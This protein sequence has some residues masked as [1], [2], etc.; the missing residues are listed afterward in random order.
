MRVL[1]VK[2]SNAGSVLRAVRLSRDVLG[3]VPAEAVDSTVHV[4]TVGGRVPEVTT[5]AAVGDVMLGRRVGRRHAGNPSA[6]LRPLSRRLASADVTVGNFEATLSTDG[7]PTQAAT[8]SPRASGC[9]QVCEPPDSMSCHWPTITS[10][11][12]ASGR[13]GRHWTGSPPARSRRSARAAMPIRRADRSSSNTAACGS[14]SLPRTPSASPGG[15][16][17]EA[18]YE[19]AEHAAPNWAAGPRRSSP[20]QLRYLRASSTGGHRRRADALGNAVHPSAGAEPAHGRLSLRQGWRGSHHRGP[21]PL[22]A[23]LGHG[24]E[25]GRRALPWQLRL[26]T[27]ISRPRPGR[28]SFSRPSSGVGS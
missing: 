19:P 27:W 17:V 21:S 25:G 8:P 6:P 1:T 23:G 28:A 22:G 26:S 24:R 9:C 20:D 10:A 14:A 15:H 5:L 13:C 3:I 16:V 7:S 11:T 2:A 12:T 4:L 18:G